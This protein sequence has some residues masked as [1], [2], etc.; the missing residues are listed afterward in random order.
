MLYEAIQFLTTPCSSAARKLGYLSQAIALEARYKRCRFGWSLHLKNSQELIREAIAQCPGQ[1]KA[2]VLGSGLLLDI[3]IKD[4]SADFEQVDL[5]DIVH[6]RAARRRVQKFHNVHLIETDITGV[7]QELARLKGT[8][9]GYT[10][11]G[12]P[13]KS[14]PQPYC[15]DQLFE[16]ADLVISANILSQLPLLPEEY[17]TSLGCENS[18]AIDKYGRSII[19]HHLKLLKHLDCMVCFIADVE[20]CI[21]SKPKPSKN[22]N[23]LY[24]VKPLIAAHSWMWNIAPAPEVDRMTHVHHRV[25]GGIIPP[26]KE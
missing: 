16:G 11:A 1:R 8:M 24:G 6:L 9:T 14:W 3:P 26:G 15:D 23:L 12:P 13:E 10:D 21:L 5:I 22:E 4:L 20:R 7:V 18:K 17:L 19:N 25:V 2:V